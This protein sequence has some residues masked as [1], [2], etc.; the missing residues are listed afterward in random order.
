MGGETEI[1]EFANEAI[2]FSITDQSAIVAARMNDQHKFKRDA[3]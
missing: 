1:C 3:A 2:P